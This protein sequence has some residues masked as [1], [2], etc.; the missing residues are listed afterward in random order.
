[1]H[2]TPGQFPLDRPRR[3]GG[4]VGAVQL[5][6][7]SGATTIRAVPYP[8][9]GL[10]ETP[11]TPTSRRFGPVQQALCFGSARNSA[12]ELGVKGTA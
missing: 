12:M 4:Q 1:M 10:P 8:R 6:E 11:E 3:G 7:R 9:R 5:S 2:R